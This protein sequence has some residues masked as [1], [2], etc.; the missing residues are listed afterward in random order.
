MT[1]ER[2]TEGFPPSLI[3]HD[4]NDPNSEELPLLDLEHFYDS[5]HQGP[6]VFP[7]SGIA[8]ISAI[9]R[10]HANPQHY[11]GLGVGEGEA[12]PVCP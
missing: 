10:S 9:R 8:P 6:L 1:N 5:P 11:F 7:R 12:T 4:C 2:P 3:V